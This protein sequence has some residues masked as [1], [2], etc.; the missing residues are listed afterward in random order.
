MIQKDL[1]NLFEIVT[2]KLIGARIV[3]SEGG[4]LIE[5]L[6]MAINTD[7]SKRSSRKFYP[8]LH[9]ERRHKISCN[10]FW[11]GCSQIE[12]LCKLD[13]KRNGFVI[14]FEVIFF[15]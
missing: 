9:T 15:N 14:Y 11:H 8:Y 3:A 5:Q 7:N 1:S 13:Q 2:G 4:E 10:C 6:S 12:L